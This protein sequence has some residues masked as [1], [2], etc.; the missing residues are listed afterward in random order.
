MLETPQRNTGQRQ[1][2]AARNERIQNDTQTNATSSIFRDI[3][4]SY[5]ESGTERVERRGSPRDKEKT[6]R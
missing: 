5:L 2:A 4:A 6:V 1:H 3:P